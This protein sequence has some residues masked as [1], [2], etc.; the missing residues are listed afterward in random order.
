MPINEELKNQARAKA[1]SILSKSQSFR[2]M[3]R[4]DQLQIYKN[5][6]DEEYQNLAQQS[7]LATGFAAADLLRE[8]R[9][10]R[11]DQAGTLLAH[12]V[13][14][15]DF[16]GFVSDLLTGVFNA[17][18]DANERQMV[19]FSKLVREATKDLAKFVN[20]IDEGSAVY[21]LVQEHSD[22]YKLPPR[23]GD[24]FD[25]FDDFGDDFDDFD[26]FG[27]G[28]S[29]VDSPD[30]TTPNSREKQTAPTIRDIKYKNGREVDTDD[31]HAKILDTKQRMAKERRTLLL[32]TIAMGVSRLVV[33]KG[34]IKAN[35]EFNINAT[36]NIANTQSARE[37]RPGRRRRVV[38]WHTGGFMGIGGTSHRRIIPAQKSQ[39][40]IAQSRSTE[41]TDL[42][43]SLTGSVEIQFKSDYF[44]LDNFTQIF[45]LGEGQVPQGGATQPQQQPPAGGADQ[46]QS[47]QQPPAG[48]Q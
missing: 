5:L 27:V 38:H 8:Q 41:N 45:D 20:E 26:D 9:N 16:P 37:E 17:N 24:D 1:R 35:V 25:D 19:A 7:G 4:G 43:G 30:Q 23:F 2:G 15:I 28:F 29:D 12:T 44:K 13:Q 6:V 22:Q 40:T 32:E 33:E 31:I 11:I 3:E 10:T 18:L 34:T 46:A 36:E 42:S 39:I 14:H 48:G 21:R 47:E